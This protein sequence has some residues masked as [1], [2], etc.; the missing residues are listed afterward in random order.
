MKNLLK[1]IMIV[2]FTL[3]LIACGRMGDLVPDTDTQAASENATS[4]TD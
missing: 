1:L 2:S 4:S 3:T